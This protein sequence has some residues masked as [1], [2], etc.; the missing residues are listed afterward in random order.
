MDI[1][2]T[3]VRR[4]SSVLYDGGQ[5]ITVS[6]DNQDRRIG[7][8]KSP[9]PSYPLPDLLP[10]QLSLEEKFLPDYITSIASHL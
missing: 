10:P 7:Y 8:F 5:M 3:W 1:T 9:H 6:G 2:A 4:K